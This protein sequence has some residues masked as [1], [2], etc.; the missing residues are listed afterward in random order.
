MVTLCRPPHPTLF[1]NLEPQLWNLP[2]PKRRRLAAALAATER[3]LKH[4][5]KSRQTSSPIPSV[6]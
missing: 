2:H 1:Y 6:A 3:T 4:Q 5:P